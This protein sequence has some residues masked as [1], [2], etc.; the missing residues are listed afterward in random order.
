[1][2]KILCITLAVF[3]ILLSVS[4]CN[5]SS[6]E[7]DSND[8]KNENTENK[9]KN[10]SYQILEGIQYDNV[11]GAPHKQE[12][13]LESVELSEPEK[14]STKELNVD[15]KIVNGTYLHT[16]NH[17]YYKTDEIFYRENRVDGMVNFGISA[18][19][20]ELTRY[21]WVDKTYAVS[22]NSS[23]KKSRDDCNN[24]VKTFLNE[25]VSDP[26]NYVLTSEKYVEIPEYE[27]VFTFEYCRK[28]G[29]LY[30]MDKIKIDVTV[31]G[32]ICSWYSVSLGELGNVEPINSGTLQAIENGCLAKL[33]KIYTDQKTN[34]EKYSYDL[35]DAIISKLSDGAVVIEYFAEVTFSSKE[36]PDINISE[37]CHL[38]AYPKAE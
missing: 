19:T 6:K 23:A 16:R 30:S 26:E 12:I 17:Y 11:S 28:I 36:N 15:G 8:S 18:D 37:L 24:I 31:Y 32:D 7:T 14:Y 22:K 34:W 38:V 29:N 1:M 27:A 2:R 9:E 25:K 20:G 33:D 4:S 21:S 13:K 35:G 3:L 10:I 5:S